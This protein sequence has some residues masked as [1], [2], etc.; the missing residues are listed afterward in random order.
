MSDAHQSRL[1]ALRA[2]WL[3][4]LEADR[5]PGPSGAQG[6]TEGVDGL[7]V[8][9][10]SN[11]YY[12]SGFHGSAGMIVVT[13]ERALL[14]SDFRYRLQAAKQAPDYEFGEVERGLLKGVGEYVGRLGV[15]RLGYE[16]AHLT[17]QAREQLAA[18][19][20]EVELVPVEGAVEQ[21]R[22]VKSAEEVAP[23]REAAK[24]ADQ[25]VAHMVTLMQPG[26]KEREIALEGEFLMR[27]RGAEA[28]AFSVIVASG[29]NGALPHAEPTDRE[30][31]LGDLVV[32]DI[33]AR[34]SGY[35]SDM[36]RTFCVGEVLEK[37]REIYDVV[38][39]A[40][41]AAAAE[42]RAGAGCRELDAVARTLITEAGYGEN[43]GHSLGHGVGIDVHEGPRLAKD[44]E[45]RL[46]AGNVVTV[47]PGI[48]L[49]G[50]GGVRLEDMVLV[51]EDGA[52][53]LTEYP[54][55]AELPIL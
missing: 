38:Y 48:Y 28:A 7:L 30:L 51:T 25:A 2:G 52:E 18:A 53:I 39:R 50:Y 8:S 12:L 29:P 40:Q 11:V 9:T 55:A 5:H 41:R 43:F 26:A 35:C 14:C 37:G 15:R 32:V 46:A 23:M 27:W 17:C 44:V 34:V 6:L 24:L 4:P 33:G 19:S 31:Q 47:E 21:L 10:P 16:S 36:T 1:E 45:T 49:A 54:M 13:R 22:A 42:V 3:S 20:G